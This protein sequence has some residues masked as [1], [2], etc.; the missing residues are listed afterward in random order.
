MFDKLKAAAGVAGLLEDLPRMQERLAAV[1][2]DL[3][4]IQCTGHSRCRHVR[5]VVNAH[6]ELL[7]VDIDPAALAGGGPDR[8][9]VQ[10]AIVDAGLG[11]RRGHE[12]GLLQGHG[13]VGGPVQDEDGRI[14]G[15]ALVLGK[16]GRLLRRGE[17]GDGSR[18]M[19]GKVDDS[20]HVDDG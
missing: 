7:S 18:A 8:A 9:A 12:F 6:G 11:Q 4:R 20:V 2:E 10:G 19:L 3:K 5:A 1:K 17:A 14:L 15:V 16:I 13:G